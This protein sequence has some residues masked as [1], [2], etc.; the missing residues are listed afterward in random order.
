MIR[1]WLFALI[2]WAGGTS[3]MAGVAGRYAAPTTVLSSPANFTSSI[4]VIANPTISVP[5]AA[6][7]RS[8]VA[9]TQTSLRVSGTANSTYTLQVRAS[10]V[11][12]TS[13]IN[14]IPVNLIGITV[15]T[16][17]IG[18]TT[19]KRLTTAYQT[20]LT[21]RPT[22]AFTNF[23]ISLQYRLYSDNALLKPAGA[24]TTTLTF[25]LTGI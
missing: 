6:T 7:Y 9:V 13:G 19:E 12:L 23:N 14:T 25:L 3:A 1:Y 21:N 18:A 15:T 20:I 22:A 17:G 5:T 2:L 10:G 16:A 11:N 8:G 4:T 24:Y